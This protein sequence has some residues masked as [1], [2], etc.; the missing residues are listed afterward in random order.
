MQRL[1]NADYKRGSIALIKKQSSAI[2]RAIRL[3]EIG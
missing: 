2:V 1:R 3:A